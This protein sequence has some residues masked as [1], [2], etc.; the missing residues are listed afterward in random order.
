MLYSTHY[1]IKFEAYNHSFRKYNETN[2]KG[3]QGVLRKTGD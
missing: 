1:S 3:D 2:K